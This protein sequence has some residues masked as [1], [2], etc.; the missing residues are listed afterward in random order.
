MNRLWY[1]LQCC[2]SWRM[3]NESVQATDVASESQSKTQWS[4]FADT[5][6]K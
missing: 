1:F 2:E 6:A 3:T 4:Y 5:L